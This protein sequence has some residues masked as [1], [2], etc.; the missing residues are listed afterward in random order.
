MYHLNWVIRVRLVCFFDALF[1]SECPR[2]DR[3]VWE[4]YLPHPLTAP[5]DH[6]TK[7]LVVDTGG[8]PDLR[9]CRATLVVRHGLTATGMGMGVAVC[10]GVVVCVGVAFCC[11]WGSA[12][13]H[14]AG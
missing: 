4:M 14:W 8:N 3:G 5:L 2:A 9:I 6:T 11:G 12:V 1:H 13:D 7:I 10:V